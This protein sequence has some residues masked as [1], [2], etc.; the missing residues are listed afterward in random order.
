MIK[1]ECQRCKK[2]FSV[3]PSATDQVCCSKTCS[4][5]IRRG[6]RTSEETKVKISNA[7]TGVRQSP[8]HAAKSREALTRTRKHIKETTGHNINWKGGFSINGGYLYF[9]IGKN[10]P[11][12]NKRGYAPVHRLVYYQ[13][14]G[15]LPEKDQVVH[16]V[17]GDKQDNRPEN[18]MLI[19]FG[20]HT[21]LENKKRRSFIYLLKGKGLSVSKY[22]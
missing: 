10:H 14:T 1:K 18:L 12:A 21:T 15:V 20:D 2:M 8:E 13:H 7:K 19:G 11:L 22:L 17:N 5:F 16:H 3:Y 6:S 4:G 9:K